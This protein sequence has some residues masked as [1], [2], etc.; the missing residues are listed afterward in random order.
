MKIALI[1]SSLARGGAEKILSLLANHWASHG[2]AVTIFTMTSPEAH[3][4]YPLNDHITVKS[5]SIVK[6]STNP[7]S[8]F[9]NNLH[10]ITTIREALSSNNP[11]VI[12]SF[13]DQTNILCLLA[14]TGVGI[15]IIVSER[16]DPRFHP[17]GRLRGFLRKHLY[18]NAAALVVQCDEFASVFNASTRERAVI[19]ENPIFPPLSTEG[20]RSPA[21]PPTILSAGRL[22]RQKGMDVLIQA[23]ALV[24]ARHPDWRLLIFGEGEERQA[25]ERLTRQLKIDDKVKLP[26]KTDSLGMAMQET[27]IF[28]LASRYEGQPNVLGEA[29]ARGMAVVATDCPATTKMITDQQNGMLVSIED[30]DS[31]S[32]AL[33]RLMANESL[34]DFMGENATRITHLYDNKTVM[35]KWDALLQ[36]INLKP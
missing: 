36:S 2:H 28:A 12:V 1:I 4:E 17:I 5:L 16:V 11:D 9:L 32:T 29:M 15:P 35:S 33:D 21:S 22:S 31:L 19:I 26:G 10:R 8:A 23:F 24:H 13:G 14:L 6:I 25:L 34:R 27:Q 18:G 3:P 20:G 7:I 30:I